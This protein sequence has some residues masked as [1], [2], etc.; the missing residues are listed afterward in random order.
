MHG[1]TCFHCGETF[2]TIADAKRHFGTDQSDDPGCLL[3]LQ[4]GETGLLEILRCREREL[5]RYRDEDSDKDREMY[6]MKADHSRALIDA[7]QKGYDKG[8]RDGCNLDP[9]EG[10]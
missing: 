10:R 7:E 8:L 1:W 9:A 3:K 6:S 4:G 5:E 2:M